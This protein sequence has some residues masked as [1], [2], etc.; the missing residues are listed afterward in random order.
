MNDL[1]IGNVNLWKWAQEDISW[2]VD[3]LTAWL[4]GKLET[5]ALFAQVG[6][7]REQLALIQRLFG[8]DYANEQADQII[9]RWNERTRLLQEIADHDRR[10]YIDDVIVR[11]LPHQYNGHLSRNWE[12]LAPHIQAAS[13][14]VLVDLFSRGIIPDLLTLER[15]STD[16]GHTYLFDP[17]HLVCV[18]LCTTPK[19]ALGWLYGNREEC[20]AHF[21]R[22]D[23]LRMLSLFPDE[24]AHF[25]ISWVDGEIINGANDLGR[26]YM[27]TLAQELQRTTASG[28]FICGTYFTMHGILWDQGMEKQLIG[29]P[30]S[31]WND[32][33]GTYC[34]TKPLQE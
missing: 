30:T 5:A 33:Y 27:G 22:Q 4:P 18:D 28:W 13:G 29:N 6:I 32:M 17:A 26:E 2:L 7:P 3:Q 34:Y 16:E 10:A 11:T 23:V 20:E 9:S 8:N 25:V 1:I 19:H 12:D 31:V 21:A 15:K 14:G 24:S